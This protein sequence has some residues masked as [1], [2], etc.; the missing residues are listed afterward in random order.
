MPQG[1][2]AQ[3]LRGVLKPEDDRLLVGPGTVDDAGVV[4]VGAREGLPEGVS[5]A[6]VQTVDFFP[7]VVDDPYLYGA[8]AA[9]N[10]LSDVYAMGGSAF[11]V[12]NL[13]G[14]PKG[15]PDAWITEIFRGGFDKVAEAGA[16]IAGGHTMQSPEA[17]FGFA[18][19][20]V[21]DREK[22]TA[23]SGA[24]IGDRIYLTKS[25]GMGT[26]TTAA[27][28]DKISWSD[29][30][31]A[32]EQMATLNRAA[33]EAM[34][35]V[36]AHACTDV[37][38]FGLIGHGYNVASASGVTLRYE[39]EKIP[40]F[41]GALDLARAGSLTGAAGRGRIGLQDQVSIGSGLDETLVSLCFDAETSGGL[42]I[43]VTPDDAARLEA[44]LESRAVPGF[45]IGEVVA[46]NGSA[47]ELV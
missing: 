22:M 47:I 29:M 16:I 43:V 8:I 12:L 35:A 26:M 5:I 27:M 31:P 24:K 10:S 41:P 11:S 46:S 7:P 15:F 21:V 39:V 9:A 30:A 20:G 13:A 18:V 32:A 19:T 6:M 25:I 37:T 14:F 45:P 36:G 1:Q 40:V 17:Q 3:V 2:L 23:N 34:C 38:G 28:R 42:L 4:L 44:E 33:A